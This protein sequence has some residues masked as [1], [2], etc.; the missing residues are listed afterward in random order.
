MTTSGDLRSGGARPSPRPLY[1][2]ALLRLLYVLGLVL[3]GNLLFWTSDG[4]FSGYP[5]AHSALLNTIAM[6]AIALTGGV[7]WIVDERRHHDEN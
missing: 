3:L 4:I 1:V 7:I 2:R 5:Q 6:I